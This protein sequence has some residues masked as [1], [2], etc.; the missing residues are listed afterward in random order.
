MVLFLFIL[1]MLF[2]FQTSGQE[3]PSVVINEIAWMGTPVAGIDAKQ[4]WRYEWLELKNILKDQSVSL[5]DWT[6]EL[7]RHSMSNSE[8]EELYFT[9]PLSGTVPAQGYFVVGASDKISGVDMNYANFGGKFL[10]TGMRVMLKNNLGEIADEVDAKSAWPAGDNE[11]KRTMERKV[12][13]DPTLLWQTSEN[14]GGTPG[15][16]NSNGLK[17]DEYYGDSSSI[18]AIGE[19]RKDPFGSSRSR[20]SRDIFSGTTLLALFLALGSG[21]GILGLRRLL[22]RPEQSQRARPA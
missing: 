5:E 1:L 6:V 13:S 11:T 4:H 3:V 14:P 17:L 8:D 22:A 15:A 9:I 19:N 10:N 21:A 12:G 20:R 16:E 18:N 2:P 7:A